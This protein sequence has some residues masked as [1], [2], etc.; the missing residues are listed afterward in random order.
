MREPF[1]ALPRPRLRLQLLASQPP[2]PTARSSHAIAVVGDKLYMFG[3]ENAPRQPVDNDM[4]V[5][6]LVKHE[7]SIASIHGD[8][9]GMSKSG[10]V[11]FIAMRSVMVSRLLSD[12]IT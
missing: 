4:H 7:W 11:W 3:G 8:V 5:F 2:S 12:R 1:V 10:L 9:P 6:D